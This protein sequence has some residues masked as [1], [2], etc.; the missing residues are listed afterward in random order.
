MHI[1]TISKEIVSKQNVLSG[2]TLLAG[3]IDG[4]H[5]RSMLL[6]GILPELRKMGCRIICLHPY[7]E[8]P[9]LDYY[10]ETGI[11]FKQIDISRPGI[12]EWLL[13]VTNAA[14]FRCLVPGQNLL[15]TRVNVSWAKKFVSIVAGTLLASQ[16]IYGITGNF[17]KKF[18]NKRE[19]K[20]FFKKT[21]IDLFLSGTPGWKYPELPYLRE[22]RRRNIPI[23]CQM[24]S[25]DN[26]SMRGPFFIR[27][28]TLML[29]NSYMKQQA[30][31]NFGQN[32][33]DIYVTG[34]PQFDVYRDMSMTRAEAKN[35]LMD[36]L[37]ID[38]TRYTKIVTFAGIPDHFVPFQKEFLYFLGDTVQN[39]PGLHDVAVVYRP[40]PQSEVTSKSFPARLRNI[41]INNPSEYFNIRARDT[42]YR[43]KPDDQSMGELALVMQGSDIVITIASSISLDASAVDT[44]VINV[45][46]DVSNQ[47]DKKL[48]R[49]Y[50]E[51]PH[52]RIVTY[53][54][55]VAVVENLDEL[56]KEIK[57]ALSNPSE[58][59]EQRRLLVNTI[60]GNS[61]RSAA[62][63]QVEILKTQLLSL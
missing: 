43:W 58:R 60:C 39:S 20:D 41:Y 54:G 53:S 23:T 45:A 12:P 18:A 59:K 31:D 3:T 17:V 57:S 38:R 11:E 14:I 55:A 44:P 27:P 52:Y 22:A 62:R 24:L 7:P 56:M 63:E 6:T 49:D 34:A 5:L 15:A 51:S 25:W 42:A 40:H 32:E 21:K 48:L 30:I 26:L 36:Y 19:V 46:F 61:N 37:G 13:L 9:E 8:T 50:Y 35:R 29:W 4:Y 16:R 10:K 1:N 47:M 33:K 2:R 28:D